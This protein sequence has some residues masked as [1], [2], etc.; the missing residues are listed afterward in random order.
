MRT[1]MIVRALTA[2]AWIG[3]AAADSA[4][5][6]GSLFRGN[7]P[8]EFQTYRSPTNLFSIDYPKRDWNIGASGM[9]VLAQF[10]FKNGRVSVLVE[11]K[12]LD[13][14]WVDSDTTELTAEVMTAN[15]KRRF[16][17]AAAFRQQVRQGTHGPMVIVEFTRPA[18]PGPD[19]E[20]R[21]FY[22]VFSESA[23]YTIA[24]TAPSREFPKH[25]DVFD[26]MALS[27]KAAPLGAAAK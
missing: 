21:R 9:T 25:A 1:L 7:R 17:N 24:C 20:I 16:P 13:R 8:V 12:L 10:T 19:A 15:L 27:F 11:Q 3:T 4:A 26:R 6:Q 22:F 2:V 14:P 5:A 18:G 23:L